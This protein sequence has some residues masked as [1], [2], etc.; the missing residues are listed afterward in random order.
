MS[1]ARH[2]CLI[3]QGTPARHLDAISARIVQE[4]KARK[5]CLFLNNPAMVASIRSYLAGRGL[6][7]NSEMRRGALALT[8]DHDHLI[9]GRFDGERMLRRLKQAVGDAL[10]DGYVGLFA[11]GDMSWEFG[12][13]RDFDRLLD[14]E[15]GLEEL[16][17]QEPALSGICQYQAD[18]LPEGAVR[19]GFYTH[20]TVFLNDTL[21]RIN[22]FCDFAQERPALMRLRPLEPNVYEMMRWLRNAE[23]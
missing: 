7:V 17:V 20:R 19:D 12:P 14:Y 11:T 1:S 13:E 21:S 6:D 22:P 5:R 4:L 23:G 3:Y 16:M 2:Q 10:N 15:S 8:S 9:D 18:S